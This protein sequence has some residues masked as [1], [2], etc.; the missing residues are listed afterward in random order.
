MTKREIWAIIIIVFLVFAGVSQTRLKFGNVILKDTL[1]GA[2]KITSGSLYLNSADSINVGGSVLNNNALKGMSGGIFFTSAAVY[3]DDDGYDLDYVTT[4]GGNHK[5]ND[6]VVIDS[7][8]TIRSSAAVMI[9]GD[10]KE[11]TVNATYMEI[12]SD[13]N[14]P[15]ARTFTLTD[16]STKGQLLI[17]TY[18]EATNQCDIVDA[19]SESG[20]NGAMVFDNLDESLTLI[21]NGTYWTELSR[22]D[23]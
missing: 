23:N 19:G 17:L 8:L 15:D 7:I 12:D 2:M 4:S 3:I 5:F 10:D 14:T 21:W 20:L 9:N 13:A 22:I 6:N 16:G 1:S 11:V 18:I